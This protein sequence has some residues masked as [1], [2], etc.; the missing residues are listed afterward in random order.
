MKC[1]LSNSKKIA[2]QIDI[3]W[4]NFKKTFMKIKR[5]TATGHSHWCLL[6][7]GCILTNDLL[8]LIQE[9][10]L[11]FLQSCRHLGCL[12][13]KSSSKILPQKQPF[14]PVLCLSKLHPALF[15]HL[16]KHLECTQLISW[17]KKN[18]NKAKVSC[19]TLL[20][21]ATKHGDRLRF[22]L[23]GCHRVYVLLMVSVIT[24]P[25]PEG[26]SERLVMEH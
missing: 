24:L 20:W 15:L 23:G 26:P 19:Q 22:F 14:C 18:Q 13:Q 2:I 7:P 21:C 5:E 1:H 17:Y 3:W 25:P 4:L 12:K 6:T 11:C 9:F 8:G 16:F 10:L